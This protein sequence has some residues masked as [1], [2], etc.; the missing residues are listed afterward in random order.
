M[1]RFR[2][3]L[4]PLLT[5]RRKAEEVHQRAVA[6]IERERL[7]LENALRRQQNAIT[8]SKQ[9]LQGSLVGALNTTSLRFHAANAVQLMRQAQ[10]IVLEMAGVHRRLEAARVELIEAARRRRAVELLR[11]R[12]FEQW[13]AEQEKAETVALDELAVISAARRRLSNDPSPGLEP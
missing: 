5:A 3:A 9:S 11:E 6:G 13:S 4:E 7:E 10:R 1:P 2:F 12:R 8:E